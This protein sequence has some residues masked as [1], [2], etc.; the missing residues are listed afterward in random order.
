MIVGDSVIEAV[1]GVYTFET[2]GDTTVKVSNG[3]TG[4][5]SVISGENT[6]ADVY[7]LQGIRVARQANADEV[8]ALPAGIYVVNGQ[9]VIVK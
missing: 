3:T 7:N 5:E 8:N 2:E 1:D 6:T 9:K 4:I